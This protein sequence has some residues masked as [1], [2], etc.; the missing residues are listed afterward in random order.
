MFDVEKIRKDFPMLEYRD[1]QGNRLVYFDN[2]ATSLKPQ[3]VIDGS[4]YYY[5][6]INA[7]IHRGDY[8]LSFRADQAYDNTRKK[9][10]EFINCRPEEV[11]YTSGTTASLNT[12]AS[13]MKHLLGKGDVILLSLAEHASNALP[14]F[15]IARETG[16]EVRMIPLEG[17]GRLTVE[18][19]RKVINDRVKIVSLAQVT[20]VLGYDVP[21]KELTAI[22]HEHGAIMVVDG[23]QSV[24]HM[25][26]DVKD[27]DCDFL[28]FSAHKMCGP[29]GLGILYGRYSLLEEMEPL[30]LGGGANAR[31]N[32]KGDLILSDIPQRFEA[33]TPPIAQVVAMGKTIDYLTELG[34]DNIHAYEKQLHDY[35]IE[36]ATKLDNIT[37]YN[38]DADGAIMAFNV[39]GVFAQDAATYLS[40]KGIAVRSGNHCA[41]MLVEHIGTDATIRASLYYYNTFAEIDYFI[42]VLRTCTVENCIGVF[43]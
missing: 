19:F 30:T 38:P 13:G 28:A 16:A 31:F 22:A 41:K 32:S 6:S 43:F 3:A 18:N 23:A 2:G 34:M 1:S 27:L 35:L 17:R 39:N 20:N 26:V 24:P 25:K 9:V 37:I 40:S 33:G 42:D 21:I 4:S 10:A 29:T 5:S 36:K 8:E 7:N 11:I 14:W 15:R 12:V